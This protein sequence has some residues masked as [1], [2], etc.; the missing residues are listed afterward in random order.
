MI[1]Y[2]VS[3]MK[4]K[5]IIIISIITVVFILTIIL[6]APHKNSETKSGATA[7]KE[8][9]GN[10]VQGTKSTVETNS[11][12]VVDVSDMVDASSLVLGLEKT[13][14]TSDEIAGLVKMREEEKLAR[15]VYTA[16]GQIWGMNIFSNIASSE[17]THTDAVKTLLNR[18]AIPDPVVNNNIGVFHSSEM[19]ELY[20]TLTEQGRQSLGEALKVGAI[21]EDL[22]INDL[23]T[24]MKATNKNDILVVYSNLQKGSRNHLRAF[25]KN[26]DKQ[27]I[28]YTP[29]YISQ[30]EYN[31]IVSANQEKGNVK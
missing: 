24:L 1:V 23:E 29:T 15:D 16:L 18:Y 3:Y 25:T 11:D 27:G 28:T 2:N 12:Y 17:Q 31:S 13:D 26:L 4:K 14:L 30:E 19:Q 20:N 21:I 8:N 9:T 5:N 10:L 7:V 6:L 22:D